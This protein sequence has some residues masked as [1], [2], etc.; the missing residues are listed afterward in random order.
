MTRRALDYDRFPPTAPDQAVR[1]PERVH[2]QDVA[3]D[4]G[5]HQEASERRLKV[6]A[7]GEVGSNSV[8]WEERD[9]TSV[10]ARP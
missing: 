10:I 1:R 4:R 2:T 5:R 7:A 3:E 6:A 9:M 8:Q